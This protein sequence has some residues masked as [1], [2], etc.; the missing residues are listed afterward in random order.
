MDKIQTKPISIPFQSDFFRDSGAIGPSRN[1]SSVRTRLESGAYASVQE[2]IK[3]IRL[4]WVLA[5]KL[6]RK[7]TPLNAMAA[8]LSEWFERRFHTFPRS[9]AEEWLLN[10]N[11]TRGKLRALV[12]NYAKCGGIMEEV[13]TAVAPEK[14]KERRIK[15]AMAPTGSVVVRQSTEAVQT[16][17]VIAPDPR[18]Q[19]PVVRQ[20]VVNLFDL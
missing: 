13:E 9:Q 6:F 2:W 11:V 7:G 8:H 14:K 10:F 19:K 1:L 4:I 16:S 3:D 18:V 12:E 17:A 20:E 15:L 5:Q